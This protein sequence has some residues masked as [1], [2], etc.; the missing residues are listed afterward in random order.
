MGEPSDVTVGQDPDRLTL[1]RFLE[2]AAG[3]SGSREALVSAERRLTYEQLHAEAVAIA[4]GLVGAGVVKG[5]HVALLLPSS[6][7]FVAAL[8]GAA[9]I[10]AVA[11]PVSTFASPEEIDHILRH[12]DASVLLMRDRLLRHAWADDLVARHPAV[13]AAEPGAIRCAAL[14]QLRRVF[15]LGRDS[16]Q[17]GIESWKDLLALGQDVTPE[18]V[19][20]LGDEVVPSDRGVIIY[21]SGSTA[22]PKGVVHSQ[23]TVAIQSWRFR[24][25]MALGPDERVWTAQPFFWTAGLC[26][27][28]GATLAAG[29]T[30]L[31]QE[32]FEPE[33][34]LAMMESERATMAHA[35]VHQHR[36]LGEHPSAAARD[37]SS[38]EKVGFHSPLRDL[39]GIDGNTW[40][41]EGSYGLSETSTICSSIPSDSP[42]E[43]RE[44]THGKPL[45]GVS[46]RIAD[47]QSGA[48]LGVGEEGEITVK[49]VTLMLGYQKVEPE[50]WRDPDGYFHT[51]DAGLIDAEGYLHWTG[52][53]TDLIK[54][55]GANVSPIEIERKLDSL[56]SLHAAR[57]VGVPHP[58]LG[59]IVVLCAVPTP[60]ASPTEDEIRAWVREHMSTYKVP[61]RVFFFSEDEFELTGNQ[62][63]KTAPLREAA[64]R[65]LEAERVEIEGHVY[66]ES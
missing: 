60:G 26:M 65:R 61:R 55:G 17:G 41:P 20:A 4:R 36:A 50:S 24:E 56:Q 15:C 25:Q 64:L 42:L 10:G 40:G 16:R 27:S 30:L 19:A 44:S 31:I 39:A 6:P 38:L 12:G 43:L 48:P 33:A 29:G 34:A 23:R 47:P 18:L 9:M 52:R 59:E 49:G 57:I 1:G 35:W 5:A 32:R 63:I 45:P 22:L 66:G 58:I 28:I 14:P 46:I 21:T 2:D 13:G 54:T 8:F 11:V 51:G 53:I 37:L 7:E 3:V 62:K